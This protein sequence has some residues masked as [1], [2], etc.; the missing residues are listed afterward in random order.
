MKKDKDIIYII[1]DKNKNYAFKKLLCKQTYFKSCLYGVELANQECL[2]IFE[3]VILS[4]GLLLS[5]PLSKSVASNETLVCNGI[6]KEFLA[7]Y[8]YNWYT[9][10]DD[11]GLME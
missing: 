7:M 9:L 6:C 11:L 1:Y 4:S 5:I 8:R 10:M 3:S 2:N